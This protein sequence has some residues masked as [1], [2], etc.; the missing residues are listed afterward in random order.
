MTEIRTEPITD[1]SAWTASDLDGDRSWDF[2]LTDV[3]RDELGRALAQVADAPLT[4][5]DTKIF[6]QPA[7]SSLMAKIRQEVQHGRGFAL[8]HGF[9]V[10]EHSFEELERLYWGLASHVGTGV[11]QNSAAGLVH[12]VTDGKRRPQQGSRGVGRPGPVGLHID[13]TDCVTLLCV[14]QAPDDPPSQL[15]SAMHVYN[16]ILRQC[17]EA[18][19]RL[20]EGFEWDRQNEH[21]EGESPTSGYR[22]PVF[23]QQDG[24]VSCRYN[25]GWI[26]PACTR[27]D[28]PLTQEE[29][30]VFDFMGQISAESCFEFPFHPGDIQFA[31][32]YTVLHGRA[33]HKE[34]AEEDRKR[35]LL[36]LWLDFPEARPVIDEGLI[37]YGLVRHGALGWTADDLAHDRHL[38]PRART[39]TGVAVL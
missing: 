4:E 12:Y 7:L 3:H 34:V 1:A 38:Q 33:G 18:L 31:N 8:L 37:R 32:N 28:K 11:T 5:L 13:L 20:Y 23:S 14:Q 35:I 6:Q 27:L 24:V 39:A 29:T 22:I 25:R 30:R 21:G 19:P 16:E 15:A 9:P 10:E 36:R 26:G 2:T 17:P